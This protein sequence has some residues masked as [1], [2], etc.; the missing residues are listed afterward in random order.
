MGVVVEGFRENAEAFE[1]WARALRRMS[2]EAVEIVESEGRNDGASNATIGDMMQT[3]GRDVYAL[4]DETK[5]DAQTIL[6]DGFAEELERTI[7]RPRPSGR[8]VFAQVWKRLGE[9]FQEL[10]RGRI[11]DQF[12]TPGGKASLSA[13]Y[14]VQKLRRWGFVAPIGKASGQYLQSIIYRFVGR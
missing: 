8:V 10:V 2:I 14:A 6:E 12:E 5:Q 4:D 11:N 1:A 7:N 3:S 13:N 9:Y